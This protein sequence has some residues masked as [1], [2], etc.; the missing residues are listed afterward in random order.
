MNPRVPP[1][2]DWT[3]NFEGI[4][5]TLKASRGTDL[6]VPTWSVGCKP[7][8]IRVTTNPSYPKV[9]LNSLVSQPYGSFLRTQR[10]PAGG[11]PPV[12]HEA[13]SVDRIDRMSLPRGSW[14]WLSMED[15]TPP[16]DTPLPG[17][18]DPVSKPG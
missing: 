3:P 8:V 1:S 13:K 16:L 7:G 15:P 14:L 2:T 4:T 5:E 11:F 12:K 10:P 17:G 18:W 6:G 9:I